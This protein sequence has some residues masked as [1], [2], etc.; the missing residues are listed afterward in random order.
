MKQR[1]GVLV[2]GFVTV[3]IGTAWVQAN[4]PSADE[5]LWAYG[6]LTPPSLA[7]KAPPPQN[8]PTRN[9]RPNEDRNDQLR[10]RR[11]IGRASCRERV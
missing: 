2:L 11:E 5:P 1:A 6:F 9:I 8:P 4:G 3:A 10:P 7:E